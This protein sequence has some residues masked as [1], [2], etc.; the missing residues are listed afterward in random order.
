MPN[1]LRKWR[2]KCR[3]VAQS[4]EEAGAAPP[5]EP[6]V[7][8]R[9]RLVAACALAGVTAIDAPF[10]DVHDTDALKQEVELFTPLKETPQCSRPSRKSRA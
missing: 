5:W 3:A 8:V 9:A 4:L 6:M 1:F 10:F 2:L 7:F